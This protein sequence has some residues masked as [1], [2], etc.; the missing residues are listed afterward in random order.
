MATSYLE[1][2]NKLRNRFNEPN[3]TAANWATV[4][5][6]DQ[7][8]K[9]A[10]NYAYHDILNAEMEW[11]FLHRTGSFLTVPGIQFYDVSTT[12][13]YAIKEVDWDSFYILLNTVSNT[14]TAEAQTIPAV[15]TYSV[16]P[17]NTIWISDL[18][19]KYASSGIDFESVDH[20]PQESG[21]YTIR[22]GVYYFHSADAGVAIELSYT[23]ANSS[24]INNTSTV[25]LYLIDYDYWRQIRLSSDYNAQ[26]SNGFG[27]PRNVFKTQVQGEVGITPVP[28]TIFNVNFEY[29]IDTDDLIN[30]SDVT[31]LPVRYEQVLLDGASKYCY[32]FREDSPLAKSTGERF[33]QGVARMRIELINRSL[34][35]RSG[36]IWRQVPYSNSFTS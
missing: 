12:D 32:E 34:D 27:Q 17:T 29:W 28:N 6:F 21:E 9:E 16:T 26:S 14:Y 24:T 31:L 8:C 19:V 25:Y 23:T 4:V 5:G 13:E 22:D 20:D 30:T 36:F 10:I 33:L 15:A 35:M 7:Y 3:L 2:V 18:G 11:P 1:L